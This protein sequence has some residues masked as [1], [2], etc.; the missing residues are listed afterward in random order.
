LDVSSSANT[1]KLMF[2]QNTQKSDL[3]LDGKLSN[4]I[5]KD[6]AS[7]RQLKAAQPPLKRSSESALLM[8]KQLRGN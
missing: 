8:A 1:L 3:R 2:L 5:E 4:F 6:R 7:M